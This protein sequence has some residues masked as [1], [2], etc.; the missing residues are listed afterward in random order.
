MEHF[1][2]GAVQYSDNNNILI[3]NFSEWEDQMANQCFQ[4]SMGQRRG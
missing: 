4:Q 2:G 1:S 3:T